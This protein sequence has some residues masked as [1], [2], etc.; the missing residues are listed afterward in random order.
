MK[1]TSTEQCVYNFL[2]KL[3]N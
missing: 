1:P 3:S 2:L